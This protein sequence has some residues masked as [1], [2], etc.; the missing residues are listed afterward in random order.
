[1]FASSEEGNIEVGLG[2][3]LFAFVDAKGCFIDVSID[4]FMDGMK[5]ESSTGFQSFEGKLGNAD[6]AIL[7]KSELGTVGLSRK[8]W[9]SMFDNL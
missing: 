5:Y 7:V 9:F 4:L 8:N 3:S 1:M 2:D 6:G